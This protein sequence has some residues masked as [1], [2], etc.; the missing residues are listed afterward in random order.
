MEPRRAIDCQ[1]DNNGTDG[2]ASK[3][4]ARVLQPLDRGSFDNLKLLRLL[5]KQGYAGP[6]GFHGYMIG[7]DVRENL[8]HTKEAWKKLC[9]RLNEDRASRKDVR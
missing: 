7:G 1:I 6:V 9:A 8:I 4:L 2:H 3:D 5:W